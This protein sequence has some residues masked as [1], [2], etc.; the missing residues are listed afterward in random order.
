M[1][2]QHGHHWKHTKKTSDPYD[3]MDAMTFS[4]HIVSD[5][6]DNIHDLREEKNELIKL[7]IEDISEASGK[8]ISFLE[9]EFSTNL[10]VKFGED[11]ANRHRIAMV[12]T[13]GELLNLDEKHFRH[14]EEKLLAFVPAYK[15]KENPLE[16]ILYAIRDRLINACERKLP[17]LKKEISTYIQRGEIIF[18]QT[19]TLV[20][21]K[22]K[23]L[24][25]LAEILRTKSDNEKKDLL[26][27]IGNSLR[28]TQC[29]LLNLSSIRIRRRQEKKSK[30]SYM[31][32]DV[33]IPKEVYIQSQFEQKRHLAFNFTQKDIHTFIEKHF[34]MDHQISNNLFEMHEP[35][36]I[37]IA[38]YAT[39][40]MYKNKK[41]Y[42]FTYTG[43]RSKNIYFETDEYIIEKGGE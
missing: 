33:V 16:N 23:E 11:S 9:D 17:Q 41:E 7:A 14:K 29:K 27:K 36:D 22:N 35:K 12:K 25:Q 13:I 21:N 15:G 6:T 34:E 4:K 28:F 39:D 42:T 40:I 1:Y 43:N 10:S 8:F 18:R 38:L 26:H 19:N 2:V 31:D 3:L 30:V 24:M 32:V 37:L 20:L 5:L